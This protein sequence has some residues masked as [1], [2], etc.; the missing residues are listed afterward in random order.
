MLKFKC[1][2]IL[3]PVLLL[4]CSEKKQFDEK[5]ATN[6]IIQL[7]NLQR[8]Y[9]FNKDSIS[10]VHQLSEDF[11]S[12]NNGIISH[13][14]K[15]NTISRYNNYFS[16]V[17]FLRWDDV[18]KPIIKF[19]KDGSLAYTI[20]DK[21]VKVTYLDKMG[22]TDI[23]ETHFVWTA[24]YRKYDDEWKIECVTSTQRP[25]HS[26]E[27]DHILVEKDLIPEGVAY[28]LNTNTIYIGSIY[29]QKIIAIQPNGDVVDIIPQ[30]VFED[31]SP[32]GMEVD[33]NKNLLWANVALS[34]IVNKTGMNQWKTTIMS[35]DLSNSQLIEKYDFIEGEQAFL[36]DLTIAKNGDVYATES[37][38]SKIYKLDTRTN[39]LTLFL[40]LPNFSF[41]NGIVYY[42]PQHCL[43][44]ATNEGIVKIDIETRKATLMEIEENSNAKAID[45]LAINAD[46]F[47]GHQSSKISKFYFDKHL[48]KIVRSEIFDS[49]DEFDS[50]TTGEVGNGHY[51]YIVNSQI[52]SG[53]NREENKL[54]PID[55]LENVIIRTKKL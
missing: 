40:D 11:I 55:S 12:V 54:K 31:L 33:N 53:I 49:G 17:D 22:G 52:R 7:H 15:N 6:E 18:T 38:N 44:V 1:I 35:F 16:S 30:T 10:F 2:T 51:H 20:V 27:K 47:I 8:E 34:P 25:I 13:P 37:V 14:N 50:S 45:G 24:I 42:Q 26:D 29:N 3:L 39:K 28:N 43:F 46:Y 36:N 32:I 48:N 23:G 9:H 4:S 21:I 19:S 41:P 5:G